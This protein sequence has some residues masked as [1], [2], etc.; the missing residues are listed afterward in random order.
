MQPASL[1]AAVQ[2]VSTALDAAIALLVLLAAPGLPPELYTED[3]MDRPV[4]LLKYHLQYNALVFYDV[5]FKR[6]YR[7][8][9]ADADGKGGRGGSSGSIR[10]NA[11]MACGCPPRRAS[12]LRCG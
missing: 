12:G 7:P 4:G 1:Q 5:R 8:A 3:V 2:A 6:I 9:A 10:S 11:V